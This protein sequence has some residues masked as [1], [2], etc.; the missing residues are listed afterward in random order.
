[1]VSYLH[2]HWAFQGLF[3]SDLSKALEDIEDDGDTT[4]AEN[5]KVLL[6][7]RIE[8]D[9]TSFQYFRCF[10]IHALT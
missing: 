7:E 8:N 2:L 1:M 10:T 4:D 9:R 6:D 5:M 3:V